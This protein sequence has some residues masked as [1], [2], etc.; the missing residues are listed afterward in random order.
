MAECIEHELTEFWGR[1]PD[2]FD[3]R[4]P[5]KV[6]VAGVYGDICNDLIE[7]NEFILS[8]IVKY[9]ITRSDD[10][11]RIRLVLRFLCSVLNCCSL[12]IITGFETDN[13]VYL[14]DLAST[15]AD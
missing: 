11:D 10:D 8:L 13:K 5:R 7:Q 3:E 1:D 9:I 2:P 14:R 4:L 6:P 12:S 15:A